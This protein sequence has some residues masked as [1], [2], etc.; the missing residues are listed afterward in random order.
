MV[1]LL[2]VGDG[3]WMKKYQRIAL[4]SGMSSQIHYLGATAQENLAAYYRAAFVTVLPSQVQESFGLGLIESLTCD[5]PVI[6]SDLPGVRMLVDHGSDG[7]L[8][9]PGG[10]DDLTRT[11]AEMLNL[12]G[13]A[14]Q[15]MGKSGRQKVVERYD[16]NLAGIRLENLYHQVLN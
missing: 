5:T 7:F 15:E 2:V 11:L 13:A 8:V 1:H 9:A 10:I 6:A 3:I 16:W 4:Q 12:S 14:R